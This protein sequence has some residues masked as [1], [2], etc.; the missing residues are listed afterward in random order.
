MADSDQELSM[1]VLT[2]AEVQRGLEKGVSQLR[3]LDC[4]L[5]KKVL[6]IRAR[7]KELRLEK[8]EIED[9]LQSREMILKL[10]V[11]KYE[12]LLPMEGN[13]S[14]MEDASSDDWNCESFKGL[15]V[16][17]KNRSDSRFAY[18]VCLHR[19]NASLTSFSCPCWFCQSP[20]KV[21]DIVP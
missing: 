2:I 3:N 1:W 5:E 10:F 11:K 9:Q 8:E 6:D 12:N 7:K 13:L 18:N 15:A 16:G 14:S 17:R 21:D 20:R 19:I 4:I